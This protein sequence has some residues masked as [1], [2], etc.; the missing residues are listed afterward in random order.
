MNIA[1]ADGAADFA[2]LFIWLLLLLLGGE[3][4]LPVL[5]DSCNKCGT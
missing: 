5:G 3:A 1:A 4:V 2:S